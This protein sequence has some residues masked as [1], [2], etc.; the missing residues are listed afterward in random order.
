VLYSDQYRY[1][2][3]EPL[4]K[5][6]LAIREKAL[7]PDHPDVAQSLNNLAT[8]YYSRG[9]FA[10]AEP[11]YKRALA[12]REKALGPDHPDVA[13]ALNNLAELYNQQGRYADALSLVR[14][15]IANK[16]AKTWP[17]LPVLFGAQGTKLIAADEAIDDGLNVMQRAS[18]TSAGEALNALA[19]RFA[20]GNDR[21]A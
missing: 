18:Q 9:R 12:I 19:V 10:D 4:E 3:A 14:T 6:A 8:L 17:A 15:T 5:R 2:D 21:L 16:T 20:A 11:L 7:G 1:A 13:T